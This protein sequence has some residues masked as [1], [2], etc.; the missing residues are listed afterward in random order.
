VYGRGRLTD[1]V[2]VGNAGFDGTYDLLAYPR[3]RT[4]NSTCGSGIR[5]RTI[6]RPGGEERTRVLGSFACR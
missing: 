6:F 2:I 1:S 5:L 3:I 4:R